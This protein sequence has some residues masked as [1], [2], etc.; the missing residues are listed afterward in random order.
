MAGGRP[1][2]FNQEIADSICETI[3]TSSKGLRAIC[4]QHGISTP[5]LLLWLKENEQFSIQYARA[6]EFQADFM[7]DDI[8]SISDESPTINPTT[9]G[10]DS[11]MV[12]HNRLRIDAR[13]WIAAKL[14]PK[15]YGEKLQQEITVSAS[16]DIIIPG[17]ETDDN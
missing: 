1:T 7:A 9:G 17:E 3:A 2:K 13:K 11:G 16:P 15:K 12:A 5:T 8:V 10:V 4:E 6:K 14:L